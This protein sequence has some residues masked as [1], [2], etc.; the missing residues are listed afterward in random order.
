M[1][2]YTALGRYLVRNKINQKFI[3]DNT[4]FSA[5]KVSNYYT[6]ESTLV[7]AD[8]F[9]RIIK[10]TPLDFDKSCEEIFKGDVITTFENKWRS[11]LGTFLF[12]YIRP[13]NYL[14]ETTGIDSVRLNKLL[15]ETNKRPYAVELYLIAKVL[16]IKPSD[17]FKYFYG[18]G[19]KPIAGV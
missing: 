16:K 10:C 7:Y 4:G 5:E 9:Y 14:S 8:E 19:D 17:L 3:V 12:E 18:D 13:Q 6:E 2:H 1:S 15:K 11:K